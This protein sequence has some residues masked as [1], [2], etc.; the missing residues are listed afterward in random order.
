MEVKV[1]KIGVTLLSGCVLHVGGF[2]FGPF[3][4]DPSRW[5]AESRDE[6][7]V[8]VTA[9]VLPETMQDL[10]T[11]PVD[12]KP[13]DPKPYQIQAPSPEHLGGSGV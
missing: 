2:E 3:K 4:H 5:W 13:Q 12:P 11:N 7:D 8:K 1:T 9:M 6:H 10:A